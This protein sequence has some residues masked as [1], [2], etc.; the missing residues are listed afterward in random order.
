MALKVNFHLMR[1]VSQQQGALEDIIRLRQ[2]LEDKK[3]NGQKEQTETPLGFVRESFPPPPI[4][5][6]ENPEDDDDV[7][8][9]SCMKFLIK[10][11]LS[12]E[13]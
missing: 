10:R 6:I 9:K 13:G 8:S 3:E 12:P 7:R 11:A 4:Q 1:R 5:D 2:T